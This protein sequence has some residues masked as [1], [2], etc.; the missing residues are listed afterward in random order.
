MVVVVVVVAVAVVAPAILGVAQKPRNHGNRTAASL[1]C[2]APHKGV[3]HKGVVYKGV[4]CKDVA[5]AVR[6]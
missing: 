4:A 1:M 6:R 3:T 2:C 5:S